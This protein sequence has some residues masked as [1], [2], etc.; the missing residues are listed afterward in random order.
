[1]CQIS[2][3]AGY[4]LERITFEPRCLSDWC[5]DWLQSA[6]YKVCNAV[7]QI[8]VVTG[9]RLEIIMFEPRCVSDW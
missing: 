4:T 9:Y 5:D 1:M 3:M 6:Q 2:V 7:C 8:G